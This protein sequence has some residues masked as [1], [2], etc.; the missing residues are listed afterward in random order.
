MSH[1]GITVT[2]IIQKI[3]KTDPSCKDIINKLY[4][5]YTRKELLMML[6]KKREEKELCK[7]EQNME[8]KSL[9]DNSGN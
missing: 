5:K 9:V 1:K 4:C 8:M 7:E 3:I 6:K 2:Q